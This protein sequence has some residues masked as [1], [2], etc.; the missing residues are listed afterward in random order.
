MKGRL[1]CEDGSLFLFYNFIVFNLYMIP[2]ICTDING[3]SAMSATT[4]KASVKIFP[5]S[6]VQ[7]P[8][9]KGIKKVV[10]IGPVATPPESNASGTKFA[11]T[12][13]ESTNTAI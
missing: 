5:P 3:I 7:R 1:I 12:K 8:I 4:P 2:L 13:I 6:V 9:E 10:V 11:G